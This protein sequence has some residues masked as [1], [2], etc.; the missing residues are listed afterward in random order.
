MVIQKKHKQTYSFNWLNKRELISKETLKNN[1]VEKMGKIYLLPK[2]A[3]I[4]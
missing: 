1:M 4:I 3:L 2:A